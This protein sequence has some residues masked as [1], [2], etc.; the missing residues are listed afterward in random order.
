MMM[1][2]DKCEFELQVPEDKFGFGGLVL[3]FQFLILLCKASDLCGLGLQ[4]CTMEKIG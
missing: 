2:G 1:A 3:P 4:E